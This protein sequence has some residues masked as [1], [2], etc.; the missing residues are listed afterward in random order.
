MRGCVVNSFQP[1][2]F[3]IELNKAMEEIQSIQACEDQ[4]GHPIYGKIL[5]VKYGNPIR[6]EDGDMMWNA[7]ILWE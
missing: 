5:D 1:A 2:T 6:D 7:L 3:E 4:N